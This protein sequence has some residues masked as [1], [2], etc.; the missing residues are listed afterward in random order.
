M[1]IIAVLSRH[2]SEMIAAVQT[3]SNDDGDNVHTRMTKR[4]R[5]QERAI[6]EP[7][8][9]LLICLPRIPSLYHSA[10]LAFVPSA[11]LACTR[12]RTML[13]RAIGPSR[14]TLAQ[15]LRDRAARHVRPGLMP[16][17]A[18]NIQLESDSGLERTRVPCVK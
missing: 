9:S 13:F 18:L 10:C 14:L 11:K 3:S 7:T 2:R 5:T 15:Q 17:L 16:P 1:N 6:G 8:S 12:S 4:A